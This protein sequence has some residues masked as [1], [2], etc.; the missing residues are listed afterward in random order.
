MN[1]SSRVRGLLPLIAV[2]CGPMSL[3]CAGEPAADYQLETS[4]LEN[5]RWLTARLWEAGAENIGVLRFAVCN[6]GQNRFPASLGQLNVRLTEK[7]EIALGFSGPRSANEKS[8]EFGAIRSASDIAATIP[9]ASHR[10]IEDP[11]A[12]QRLFTREY[13]LMWKKSDGSETARPDAFIFGVAEISRD[14]RRITIEL[15]GFVRGDL[16][17]GLPEKQITTKPFSAPIDLLDLVASGE[18]YPMPR[19]AARMETRS[20]EEAR[21]EARTNALSAR[22][23]PKEKHPLNDP[24]RPID[25]TI[26]YNGQPQEIL[27]FASGEDSADPNPGA[28]VK[29]P[30]QGQKVAFAVRRRDPADRTRYGILL[31]VNGDSTLFKERRPNERCSLWVLEPDKRE[32]RIEGFYLEIG[33][34]GKVAPFEV[35][36]REHS[37]EQ[38]LL[39]GHQTGMISVV[40]YHE[41]KGKEESNPYQDLLPRTVARSEVPAATAESRSLFGQSLTGKFLGESTMQ[42]V[43]SPSGRVVVVATPTTTFNRD[44]ENFWAASVRYYKPRGSQSR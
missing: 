37:L 17:P 26:L 4:L 32:F 9:G 13:P 29:D 14:L 23:N 39:Y 31:R 21:E 25:L 8:M 6:E 28:R 16:A 2:L 34:N 43:I 38:E 11:Q 44:P 18:G 41:K 30:L 5:V 35:L 15:T 10:R 3:A 19:G 12:R 22:L 42:G 27:F 1:L 36:D 7:T 33:E 24:N 40:V 20:K